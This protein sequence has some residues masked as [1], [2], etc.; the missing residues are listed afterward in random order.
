MK[1][2]RQ[3]ERVSESSVPLLPT[4][5]TLIAGATAGEFF[6]GEAGCR[7]NTSYTDLP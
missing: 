5:K 3:V 2:K 6:S 1:T 7:D 4:F